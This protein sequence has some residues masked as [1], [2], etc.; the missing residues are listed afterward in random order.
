LRT[1]LRVREH[2]EIG[3]PLADML[4]QGK[5][6][7]YE[8]VQQKDYVQARLA[9]DEVVFSAGSYV[10]VI[11]LND[12]FELEVVPKVP[13]TQL[14]H[15]VRV[16]RVAPQVLDSFSRWY[17]PY[18]DDL[19]SVLDLV[20]AV[21]VSATEEVLRRGMHNEYR[22]RAEVTSFPKGRLLANP[23]LQLWAHR[24]KHAVCAIWHELT[25]DTAPNQL[26]KYALWRMG[27]LLGHAP[28]LRGRLTMLRELQRLYLAFGLVTLRHDYRFA[29]IARSEW[30]AL[31]HRWQHYESAISVAFLVIEN[32]G[33][34]LERRGTSVELPSLLVNLSDVFEGYVRETLRVGLRAHGLEAADGNVSPPLG[35]RKQL[36]EDTP[37]PPITP[38]VVVRSGSHSLAIVDV[39]YKSFETGIPREDVSQ[40]ISY[41][42]SYRASV[43]VLVH[44]AGAGARGIRRLGRVGGIAVYRYSM[45]LGGSLLEEEAAL[46]RSILDLCGLRAAT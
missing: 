14:T 44:P 8:E 36:F 45:D 15:M 31:S 1:L 26:I 21:L 34:D 19:N 25:V 30:V 22:P 3:I 7:L 33:V 18:R 41:A 2:D 10:G 23:T 32:Q 9:R 35:A 28:R 37:E 27:S 11:P 20:S 29:K 4:K 46:S 39:K 24:K 16:A 6:D 38:D 12:R 40:A 42:L 5:V 13:L 17:H 43:A